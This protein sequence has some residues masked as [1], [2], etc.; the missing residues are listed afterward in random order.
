MKW[1]RVVQS[2]DGAQ[3]AGT[4]CGLV[5]QGTRCGGAGHGYWVVREA[6]TA[7]RTRVMRGGD[8]VESGWG[9]VSML[10]LLLAHLLQGAVLSHGQPL[11]VAPVSGVATPTT[12][13][14]L[15]VKGA[16]FRAG[17]GEGGG[18][19]AGRARRARR[20]IGAG[21]RGGKLHLCHLQRFGWRGRRA[22]AG[23]GVLMALGAH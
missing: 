7:G 16:T 17:G 22:G 4:G 19:Q 21:D 10:F 8:R 5:R 13:A 20:D 14:G 11:C 18:L 15:A 6:D 23:G 2:T 3:D 12:G 9:T 1:T